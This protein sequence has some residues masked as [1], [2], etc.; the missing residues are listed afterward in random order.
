MRQRNNMILE[1]KKLLLFDLDGTLID[2]VPDLCGAVNY[3]LVALDK[4]PFDTN[5]IREWVGNGAELLVKRALSGKADIDDNIDEDLFIKA[6]S[7]FLEYYKNNLTNETILYDQVFETIKILKDNGF[8]MA[9]I[10]NK[11]YE[12]IEPILKHF[13]M[14]SD[15]D[16]LL[17]ANSLENKKPHP[18]PLLYACQKLNI[19]TKQTIMVGDSKNDILAAQNANIDSIAVNYGYNYGEDI[20]IYNP[21]IIIDNFN[22]LIKVC[23]CQK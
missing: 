17:G 22:E 7:I 10:T 15:F 23:K 21:N 12:F 13:E 6:K 18:Q 3:M 16:L 1:N 19:D 8:K 5:I 11:P 9:I 2:S 20:A 14:D 4:I